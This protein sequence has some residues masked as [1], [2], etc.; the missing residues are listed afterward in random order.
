MDGIEDIEDMKTIKSEEKFTAE[1]LRHKRKTAQE[2]IEQSDHIDK[3]NIETATEFSILNKIYDI[4][5]LCTKRASS[6]CCAAH[7]QWYG[8]LEDNDT[9]QLNT[10]ANYL[11]KRGFRVDEH[12]SPLFDSG[13]DGERIANGQAVFCLDISWV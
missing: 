11:K 7:Y 10:I 2:N 5:E 4:E 1:N 9:T 12:I 13:D 8:F 6:A 3:Q